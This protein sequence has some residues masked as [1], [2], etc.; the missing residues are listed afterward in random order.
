MSDENQVNPDRHE[1]V[2]AISKNQMKLVCP[3]KMLVF[4][5][6]G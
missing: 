5:P 3:F 4:G 2:I 6:A 1:Q